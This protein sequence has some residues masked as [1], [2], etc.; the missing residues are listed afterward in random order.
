MITILAIY[1]AVKTRK[2]KA[3]FNESTTM[4]FCI[5]SISLLGIMLVPISISDVDFRVA[6]IVQSV[7]VITGTTVVFVTFIGYKLYLIL[8]P[9][10][11]RPLLSHP[12]KQTVNSTPPTVRDSY[13]LSLK[14]TPVTTADTT[15]VGTRWAALTAHP[16]LCKYD[17]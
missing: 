15:M 14:S 3:D 4:A 12:S 1:Y 6:F 8:L 10:S 7:G 16:R 9:A 13:A 5:Y 11:E 17:T 2:V